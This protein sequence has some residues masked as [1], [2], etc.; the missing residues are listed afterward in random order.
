MRRTRGLEPILESTVLFSRLKGKFSLMISSEYLRRQATICLR[1]AATIDNRKAAATLV[2]M[3][4]DFI[5]K[6]ELIDETEQIQSNGRT[7][8]SAPFKAAT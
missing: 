2:A 3:A 4:D 8:G 6:A 5:A 1:L 7:A